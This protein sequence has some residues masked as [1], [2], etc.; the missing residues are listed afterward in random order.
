MA[1]TYDFKKAAGH[2]APPTTTVIRQFVIDY[3]T[4]HPSGRR[5]DISGA[6]MRSWLNAGG[7]APDVRLQDGR[8]KKA[9][10]ALREEGVVELVTPQTWALR[11]HV[12]HEVRS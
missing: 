5:T 6:L 8:V 10:M 1:N 4:T 3:L 7:H 9:L 12:D 11:A 2:G